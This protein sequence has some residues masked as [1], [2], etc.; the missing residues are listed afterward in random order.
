MIEHCIF[1]AS[2]IDRIV[3]NQSLS[4][5]DHEILTCAINLGD[6][7]L[8]LFTRQ[9]QLERHDAF[10][11]ARD[12][13]EYCFL[14]NIPTNEVTRT[15]RDLGLFR[16]KRLQELIRINRELQDQVGGLNKALA[17]HL[18]PKPAKTSQTQPPTIRTIGI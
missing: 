13:A 5:I 18:A 11:T 10:C 14:N 7:S 6:K 17:N 3:R 12:V 16:E 9:Y 1:D 15:K 2:D 4:E 8:S